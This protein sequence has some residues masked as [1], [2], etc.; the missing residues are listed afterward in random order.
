MA[1]GVGERNGEK[2]QLDAAD[3]KLVELTLLEGSKEKAAQPQEQGEKQ[4]PA[5]EGDKA[6]VEDAAP[7]ADP[8]AIADQMVELMSLPVDELRQRCHEV[9]SF[10]VVRLLENL[11]ETGCHEHDDRLGKAAADWLLRA[12][13]KLGPH[14][15]DVKVDLQGFS[16]L[17][18]ALGSVPEGAVPAWLRHAAL[19][20]ANWMDACLAIRTLP[21]ELVMSVYEPAVYM[22]KRW[23][24]VRRLWQ[25]EWVALTVAVRS[26]APELFKYAMMP[27][28]EDSNVLLI[29]PQRRSGY[30]LTFTGITTIAELTVFAASELVRAGCD[31][32]LPGSGESFRM[33][34]FNWYAWTPM[35]RLLQEM[36]DDAGDLEFPVDIVP[37]RGERVVLVDTGPN[38]P[39]SAAAASLPKEPSA[40]GGCCVPMSDS[41]V[42][43]LLS[44]FEQTSLPV[45]MDIVGAQAAR[46]GRN[47]WPK[48][49]G[50]FVRLGEKYGPKTGFDG[51]VNVRTGDAISLILS[52]A[53]LW[54]RRDI[55]FDPAFAEQLPRKYFQQLNCEWC[56]RFRAQLPLSRASSAAARGVCGTLRD[57][58]YGDLI[59]GTVPADLDTTNM[60][61]T[62]TRKGAPIKTCRVCSATYFT[63]QAL[64]DEDDP[65]SEEV[66]SDSD[67]DSEEEEAA[68]PA[69]Q[70]GESDEESSSGE[71]Q[72]QV[73]SDS[74]EAP[75]APFVFDAAARD[76]PILLD[77]PGPFAFGGVGAPAPV[78]ANAL[79]GGGIGPAPPAANAPF[80]FGGFGAQEPNA[81]GDEFA[82][83]D[84][85][86]PMAVAAAVAAF[87]AQAPPAP[88][89]F[90]APEGQADAPKFDFASQTFGFTP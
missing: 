59:A 55:F 71:A 68:A 19:S 84:P 83:L 16:I 64:A 47:L 65:T 60:A 34:F 56:A 21:R 43:A 6:G 42:D 52:E 9:R 86:D 33:E 51:P 63:E 22:C 45:R 29:H 11:H 37:F 27:L 8:G 46:T 88:F 90:E 69:P 40:E 41:Q 18:A 7:K 62:G 78:A 35:R 89:V 53:D 72:G 25:D 48:R 77:A 14:L 4:E 20:S 38:A 81:A 24:M 39:P 67:S 75:S 80:V 28:P 58:L 61:L 13:A 79:L 73:E 49:F 87:G 82:I 23:E 1:D 12:R 3:E 44:A 17:R 57:A 26:Y 54:R 15:I 85:R 70:G 36:L 5:P 66:D 2:A 30:R 74:E 32:V 31:W 76:A 10:L 50:A